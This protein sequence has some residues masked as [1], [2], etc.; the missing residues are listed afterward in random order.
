MALVFKSLGLG[1][2]LGVDSTAS[3]CKSND[4]GV[5]EEEVLHSATAEGDQRA[6]NQDMD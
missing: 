4:D 5:P 6:A 3:K 2:R 1:W